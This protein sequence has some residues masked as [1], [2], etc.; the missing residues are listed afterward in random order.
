MS[1]LENRLRDAMQDESAEISARPD[2][3]D[4]MVVRGM[5]VRRRRRA[6]G[7]IA[8][9]A[10]VAAVLPLWK[11]IDTSADPTPP[12]VSPPVVTPA[13]STPSTLGPSGRLP[14]WST[15]AVEVDHLPRTQARLVGVRVGQHAGYDRLV[16][17]LGGQLPGYQVQTVARLVHDGSGRRLALPGAALLEV[18]LQPAVAHD[19]DARP[20]F[21]PTRQLLSL[22]ALRGYALAGDVEGVVTLGISLTH[23]ST[24]RVFELSSPS[25]LVIDVRHEDPSHR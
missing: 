14:S 11:A 12:A 15:G 3:A 5:T 25:R 23:Q 21:A 10:L 16:I 18:R 20:T 24:F 22:P 2:L 19:V 8:A 4:D 17:D 7:G 1:E 13:P 9:L 6:A